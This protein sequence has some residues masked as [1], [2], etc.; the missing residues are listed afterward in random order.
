[1]FDPHA[2]ILTARCGR[3][4]RV[5]VTF[6]QARDGATVRCPRCNEAVVIEGDEFAHRLREAERALDGLRRSMSRYGQ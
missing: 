2:T 5:P 3:R 1:M 6:Q 4:H